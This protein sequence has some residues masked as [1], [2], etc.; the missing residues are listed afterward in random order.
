MQ[1]DNKKSIMPCYSSNSVEI[2]REEEAFSFISL[3]ADIG[4]ILGLFIGFNFLMVWEW[5]VWAIRKLWQ[6]NVVADGI[7]INIAPTQGQ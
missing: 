2:Q 6:R 7:C 3:I 4:G 1:S 5:I